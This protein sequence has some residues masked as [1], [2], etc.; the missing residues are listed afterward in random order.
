MPSDPRYGSFSK[1]ARMV[2]SSDLNQNHDTTEGGENLQTLLAPSS[3]PPNQ[4]T[5]R[6]QLLA[7]YQRDFDVQAPSPETMLAGVVQRYAARV[8]SVRM[9][10]SSRGLCNRLA[11]ALGVDEFR[12]LLESDRELRRVYAHS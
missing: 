8:P 3:T 6:Q 4:T 11:V 5:L 9:A 12:R 10:D 7:Q 1:I 2:V